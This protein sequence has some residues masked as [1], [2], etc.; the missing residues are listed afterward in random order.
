VGPHVLV[1]DIGMPDRDGLWL[2]AQIRLREVTA[3]SHLPAVALTAFARPEDRARAL[4]AGYE[5]HL[6]KPA[7]AAQLVMLVAALAGPQLSGSR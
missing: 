1:S 4:E 3:G 6:A 2:I 7:D 5:H